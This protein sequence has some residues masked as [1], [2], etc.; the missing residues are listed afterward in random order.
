MR[1]LVFIIVVDD[2]WCF[3]FLVVFFVYNFS[4]LLLSSL[5]TLLSK[6]NRVFT[7]LLFLFATISLPFTPFFSTPSSTTTTTSRR[8]WRSTI[9]LMETGHKMDNGNQ[10]RLLIVAVLTTLWGIRL[11]WN[12]WRKGGYSG[13]EDYRWLEVQSKSKVKKKKIYILFIFC[14]IFTSS[15]FWCFV[16]SAGS[17]FSYFFFFFDLSDTLT[18]ILFLFSSPPPPPTLPFRL[19][20]LSFSSRLDDTIT[21]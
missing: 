7:Y 6:Q 14:L 16:F 18:R 15:T 12:F 13:G 9:D 20:F 19:P 5:H 3:F 4:S 1:F 11:T 21:I 10:Q 2:V 17:Y 8:Y